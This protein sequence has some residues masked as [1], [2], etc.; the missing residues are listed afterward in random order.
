MK[1][2]I[3]ILIAVVLTVV[4]GLPFREYETQQLLPIKTLQAEYTPDGVRIVS[5]VAHGEGAT[6]TEAVADLRKNAAGDVFFDT[7]EQVVLTDLNL[8]YAAA[9]SGILRPSAQVYIFEE[10]TDPE[11]LNAYLTAHPSDLQISDFSD[12]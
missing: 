4:F 5:E 1:G 8:A 12:S 11:G 6:W 9:Q 7:A 3:T 2:W 10:L